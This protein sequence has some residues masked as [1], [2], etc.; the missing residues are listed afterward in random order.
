MRQEGKIKVPEGIR[1][2]ERIVEPP[3]SV[4]P[5][6]TTNSP[7]WLQRFIDQPSQM[8][9]L[10]P[11]GIMTGL[12]I[13]VIFVPTTLQFSLIVG[14][15]SAFYFLYRKEQKLGRT[16]LL[17]FSGL[18]LGLLMG[19]GLYNLLKNWLPG[20]IS[21]PMDVNSFASAFTFL[22]LWLISSFLR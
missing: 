17:G 8:D 16:A 14:L 2:P 6:F 20:T 11:A 13:L 10:W 19:G 9:I 4:V 7:E 22:I 21:I 1:F 15:G 18:I 5:N 3:V 12:A